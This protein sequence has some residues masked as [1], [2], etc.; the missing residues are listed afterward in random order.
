MTTR[1][2]IRQL[3]S[4]GYSIDYKVRY[5][6]L[7]KAGLKSLV[8]Q[9][10]KQPKI[11]EKEFRQYLAKN[12]DFTTYYQTTKFERGIRIK[13]IDGIK[14]TG[15]TGNKAL[16]AIADVKLS[17]KQE[18]Q[19]KSIRKP[20]VEPL[21]KAIANELRKAQ[22]LARKLTKAQTEE[23]KLD[24]KKIIPKI[25]TK[26]IR[27][28]IKQHGETKAYEVLYNYERRIKKLVPL[29]MW[30]QFLARV[31]AD[32]PYFTN[33]EETK[34]IFKNMSSLVHTANDEKINYYNDYDP[35]RELLY[36]AEDLLSKGLNEDSAN[37]LQQMIPI[38]NR[39]Q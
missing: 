13:S 27:Y 23:E 10:L 9:R 15:S 18:T 3:Q 4:M 34:E 1:E 7:G 39:F 19:L 16:R 37:K 29:W 28:Q 35:L 2:L 12:P 5:E 8:R 6:R 38:L 30:D 25:T 17:V 21:P 14:F 31:E 32:Y 20:R 24:P 33:E 11:S 36:D 22:T 26:N